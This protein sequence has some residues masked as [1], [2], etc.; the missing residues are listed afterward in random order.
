MEQNAQ[1]HL[2]E[3]VSLARGGPH[4]EDPDAW[5]SGT[6]GGFRSAVAALRAVAAVTPEEEED[7]TNRMMVALGE[8]PLGPLESIPGVS[9]IRL[10][11]FGQNVPP[12]PPSPPPASRFLAL[13]PANEPDRPLDYGGRVQ[14]LGVELYSDKVTVNW[15]LAPEPDYEAVFAVELAE[16]GDDLEGLSELQRS[17]LRQ[18]FVHRLQMQRSFVRLSDDLGTEYQRR[19]GG[20]SGGGNEKRGHTEFLPSVPVGAR[21][22]TVTW[23]DSTQFSV[24]LS[25]GSR[26]VRPSQ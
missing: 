8:E 10:V 15:R 23:D 20:S 25:S 7:W 18:R 16:Q 22:L 9:R 17:H 2:A 11:S 1:A 6:F 3:L 24:E 13:V 21:H 19:G 14:I 5:K 26:V 12:R 4:A